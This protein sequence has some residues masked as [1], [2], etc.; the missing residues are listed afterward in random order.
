MYATTR[1]R[2]MLEVEVGVIADPETI[3]ARSGG[4]PEVIGC[5]V[6]IGTDETLTGLI[7]KE[8]ERRWLAGERFVLAPL[9]P[10]ENP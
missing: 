6:P 4:P 9:G 8:F 5:M 2:M 3:N 7:R 1:L 10:R